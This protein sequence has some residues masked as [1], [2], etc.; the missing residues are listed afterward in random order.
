MIIDVILRL[1]MLTTSMLLMIGV[2]ECFRVCR[3]LWD[4]G[5]RSASVTYLLIAFLILLLAALTFAIAL[6]VDLC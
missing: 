6:F 1:M 4:G 2:A 3:A 5:E